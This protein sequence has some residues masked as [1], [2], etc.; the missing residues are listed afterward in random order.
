V[1]AFT[2]C[3]TIVAAV[4]RAMIEIRDVGEATTWHVTMECVGC[5]S[6]PVMSLID[7]A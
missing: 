5:I 6:P 7:E 1:Y 3:C 2:F 4:W